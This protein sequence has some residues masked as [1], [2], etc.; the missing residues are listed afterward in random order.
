M[1]IT[2]SNLKIVF[3]PLW[4]HLEISIA[5]FASSAGGCFSLILMGQSFILR[6][7]NGLVHHSLKLLVSWNNC[8]H[9]FWWIMF[10][11]I[12]HSCP[13]E[14]LCYHRSICC[15]LPGKGESMHCLSEVRRGRDCVSANAQFSLYFSHLVGQSELCQPPGLVDQDRRQWVPCV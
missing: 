2:F 12:T 15:Y 14:D 4:V 13:P 5:I 7:H 8:Y 1:I 11:N 6:L 9:C 10:P 3:P